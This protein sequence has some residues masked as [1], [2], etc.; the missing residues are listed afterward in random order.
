MSSPL[1]FV[2]LC[3]FS[4]ESID[5]GSWLKA[6]DNGMHAISKYGGAEPGDRTMVSTGLLFTM[7]S[8][9]SLSRRLK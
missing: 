3:A 5:V 2:C 7:I 1:I 9:R 4:A 6:W 8:R